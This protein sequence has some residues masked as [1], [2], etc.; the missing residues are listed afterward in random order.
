MPSSKKSKPKAKAPEPPSSV[1]LKQWLEGFVESLG[2]G[3]LT[4]SAKR[5][6]MTPSGLLKLINRGHFHEPTLLCVT[7]LLEHKAEL[8]PEAVILSSKEINGYIFEERQVGEEVIQTW[9]KA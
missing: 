1:A 2:N 7:L 6:G 3:G 9:R 8:Y 4:F 5:L